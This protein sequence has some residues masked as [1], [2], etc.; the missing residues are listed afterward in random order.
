MTKIPE[1]IDWREIEIDAVVRNVE[2]IVRELGEDTDSIILQLE[3]IASVLRG[4]RPLADQIRALKKH[5]STLR[6]LANY[7]SEAKSAAE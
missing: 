4:K 3:G 2:G 1:N 5:R 7:I 6:A